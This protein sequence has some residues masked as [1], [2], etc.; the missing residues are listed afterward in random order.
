MCR[1]KNIMCEA[2]R[3]AQFVVISSQISALSFNLL[4][5]FCKIRIETFNIRFFMENCK[6][7]NRKMSRDQGFAVT[8][9]VH[10]WTAGRVS[11]DKWFTA[12]FLATKNCTASR[13]KVWTSFYIHLRCVC[14]IC[15]LESM[16]YCW[17]FGGLRSCTSTWWKQ[18]GG[19]KKWTL[20]SNQF[21][22]PFCRTNRGKYSVPIQ[23]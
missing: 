19:P 17:F 20:S 6:P 2:V 15:D 10:V 16:N 3:G 9:A 5:R 1:S 11:S 14:W 21:Y 4:F 22:I 8:F 23:S 7:A 12:R 13:L 18:H